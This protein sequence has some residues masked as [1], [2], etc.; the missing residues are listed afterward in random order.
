MSFNIHNEL[1]AQYLSAKTLY[2]NY[3]HLCKEVNLDGF[4][5]CI[6]TMKLHSYINTE[7]SSLVMSSC[8]SDGGERTL[9]LKAPVKDI[10]TCLEILLDEIPFNPKYKELVV[11]LKTNLT[12]PTDKRYFILGKV[13]T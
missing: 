3:N 7:F 4:T 11:N 10:I 5:N 2:E 13:V 6:D 8:T 1:L 12:I 9:T